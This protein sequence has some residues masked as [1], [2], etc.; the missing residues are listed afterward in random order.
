MKRAEFTLSTRTLGA[1]LTVE[2]QAHESAVQNKTIRQYEN[3]NDADHCVVNIFV[4]YF[5]FIPNRDEHSYF[6][7]LPHNGS[8]IPRSVAE[9]LGGGGGGAS[10]PLVFQTPIS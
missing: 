5:Y 2:A 8:G 10:A 1:K 4:K 3:V 7:P 9:K 6:R